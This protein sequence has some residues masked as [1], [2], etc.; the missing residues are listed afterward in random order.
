MAKKN[1][2]ENLDNNYKIKVLKSFKDV[3]INHIKNQIM[4]INENSLDFY[5][6][7]EKKEYIKFI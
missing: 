5:K 6:Q 1:I 7:M 4:N 3:G 2:I